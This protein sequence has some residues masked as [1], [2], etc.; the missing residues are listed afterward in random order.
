MCLEVMKR[1][2]TQVRAGL[3][4]PA[5]GAEAFTTRKRGSGYA[6]GGVFYELRLELVG[7]GV[8]WEALEKS[9]HRRGRETLPKL[10][11]SKVPPNG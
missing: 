11:Q 2:C 10:C 3:T 5:R 4:K 7:I 1:Q 6:P 8:E 9:S